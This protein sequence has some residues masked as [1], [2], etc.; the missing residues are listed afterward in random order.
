MAKETIRRS[1]EKTVDLIIQNM[2]VDRETAS[3][4]YDLFLTALSENGIPSRTGMENI[5]R[6][7]KSQGRFVERKVA[8][9]DVADDSLAREVAKQTGYKID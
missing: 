4:T 6:A 7:I 2:K 8:F 3:E 5:I 9:E 1:R